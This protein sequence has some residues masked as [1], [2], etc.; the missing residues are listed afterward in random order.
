[1]LIL[2]NS[3]GFKGGVHFFITGKKN[4]FTFKG[5]DYGQFHAKQNL[6]CSQ[7]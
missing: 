2:P 3:E 5:G 4:R 6:K 7:S 1:M